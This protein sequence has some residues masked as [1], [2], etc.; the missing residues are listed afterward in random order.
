MK[1]GEKPGKFLLPHGIIL[2]GWWL[3]IFM[4]DNLYGIQKQT[5]I[6]IMELSVNAK[7]MWFAEALLSSSADEVRR[8][9]IQARAWATQVGLPVHLWLSDRHDAFVT[10]IAAEFPGGPASVWRQSFSARLGQANAGGGEARQGQDA[11]QSTRMA[12]HRTR[13]VAATVTQRHR[14]AYR[15]T[16]RDATCDPRTGEPG[17]QGQ[18]GRDPH[19]L[20]RPARSCWMTGTP[21]VAYSMT[22]RACLTTAGLTHGGG[23]GRRPCLAPTSPGCSPWRPR[24]S[25]TPALGRL[26]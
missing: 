26:Y 2:L 11:Q 14:R 23:L 12:Y 1:E 6:R 21:C 8:L 4:E 9:L 20:R 18:S 17:G 7:R 24:A 3:R 5:S 19:R 15:C 22:I 13:G 16:C 25:P 10:G